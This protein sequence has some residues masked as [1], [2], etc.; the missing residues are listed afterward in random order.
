MSELVVA[1]LKV[2]FL[3]L[4]WVFIIFAASVIR[5][6]LFGREL[7]ATSP[8]FAPREPQTRRRRPPRSAPTQ[9]KVIQGA[10]T[11][12]EVPL[13]GTVA[14]GRAA[15]STLNIDDDYASTRHAQITQD[16]EGHWWVEDL[17]STNGTAVNTLLITQRT[18]VQSGDVIR[19][20][21]TQM[22]LEKR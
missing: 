5:S 14:L 16:E 15:D 10:Q 22:R 19:I 20:G 9:L 11:G 13:I 8:D 4:M 2:A 21:R 7:A 12:L 18:R 17:G 1:A 3:A 6:D